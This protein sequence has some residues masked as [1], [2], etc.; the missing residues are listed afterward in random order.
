MS[1]K[2]KKGNIKNFTLAVL[3]ILLAI[4]CVGGFFL[5]NYIT[6]NDKFEIIGEKTIVL[7]LG[8][9]YEDEK[10]V[11]ISFGKDISDKVVS[12]NNIDYSVAGEYYIKYSVDDFRFKD[13]Y[14]Y[15]YILIKEE[16]SA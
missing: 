11:V 3:V 7:T 1:K 2:A 14:R 16:A 15:R 6:K 13:V 5:A 10:A 9:T 4:G 8:E 12:E